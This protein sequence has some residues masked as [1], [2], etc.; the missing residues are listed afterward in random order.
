MLYYY[1][2]DVDHNHV[3]RV[4]Q[5]YDTMW[6]VICA[7]GRGEGVHSMSIFEFDHL[8][9]THA[10]RLVHGYDFLTNTPEEWEGLN[11]D[12]EC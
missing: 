12:C 8:R 10:M 1:A 4:S 5:H 9:R 3:F 7:G 6:D 2:P 11:E